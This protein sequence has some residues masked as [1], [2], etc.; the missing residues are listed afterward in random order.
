MSN[1]LR[2]R[3]SR[4]RSK[5]ITAIN[6]CSRKQLVVVHKLRHSL[7]DVYVLRERKDVFLEFCESIESSVPLHL[8]YTF[9]IQNEMDVYL[10]VGGKR[11]KDEKCTER[12]QLHRTELI[13]HKHSKE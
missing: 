8:L 2:T 13:D 3:E 1:I 5:R 12:A 6:N 9:C 7:C 4:E 11:R 10:G